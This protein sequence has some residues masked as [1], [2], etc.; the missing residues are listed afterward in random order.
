MYHHYMV[1]RRVAWYELTEESR[2]CYA[3]KHFNGTIINVDS[4]STSAMVVKDESRIKVVVDL[5]ELTQ[6]EKAVQSETYDDNDDD[7]EE[8]LPDTAHLTAYYEG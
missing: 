8:A 6:L 7:Y 4:T 1:N 5:C 2:G 3:R